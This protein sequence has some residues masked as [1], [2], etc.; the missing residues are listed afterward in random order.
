MVNLIIILLVFEVS[1]CRFV[2]LADKLSLILQLVVSTICG[3]AWEASWYLSSD[4]TEKQFIVRNRWHW[5]W[6]K[7]QVGG[8][9][10][11]GLEWHET[12]TSWE[13]WTL[14]WLRQQVWLPM[15]YCS[16]ITLFIANDWK[17]GSSFEG[18]CLFIVRSYGVTK[19]F[20]QS[21]LI[22][23]FK[24]QV[25]WDLLCKFVC[26]RNWCP[27]NKHIY[28]YE[29][30]NFQTFH[31]LTTLN[32]YECDLGQNLHILLSFLQ[33]TPNLEKVILQNCEVLLIVSFS[34]SC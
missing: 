3:G 10:S 32:I 16:C 8:I 23:L 9:E 5:T 2:M 27:C 14:L 1:L 28:I 22:G 13:L 29:S 17:Q 7:V 26:K 24:I 12:W 19:L 11:I 15:Y 18:F 6:S 21:W 25:L 31:K 34:L 20:M 33:N 30:A 4:I